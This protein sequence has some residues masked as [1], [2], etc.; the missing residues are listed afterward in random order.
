MAGT[1]STAPSKLPWQALSALLHQGC[2]L[3]AR[4]PTAGGLAA[5]DAPGATA[6][7]AHAAV[8]CAAGYAT[9]YTVRQQQQQ[10]VRMSLRQ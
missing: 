5:D 6:A 8:D 1:Q 2:L 9:W 10:H 3:A 7:A 4:S